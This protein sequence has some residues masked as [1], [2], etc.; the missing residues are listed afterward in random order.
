LHAYRTSDF[1]ERFM[2]EPS[3]ADN[4][5]VTLIVSVRVRSGEEAAFAEW[6]LRWQK[7]VLAADGALSCDLWPAAPP[8]QDDSVAVIRFASQ[9]ALRAWRASD[10]HNALIAEVS[11]LV[12]GGV[13][14]QLVGAV[15]AA[16]YVERAATELIVTR[17]LPGKEAAY[18][19]WYARIAK[20]QAAAPGFAGA[21]VHPPQAEEDA[22]TTVLRFDTPEHLNG[23]LTSPVRLA[24]LEE[25]EHLSD[26]L[27]FQ[28][29]DT[30]F[31]G[32]TAFDPKTGKPPSRW[33]TAC[34]VVLVLLPVVLLE[35][36]YLDPLI[37]H[38]HRT[39]WTLV[40]ICGG[41][42]LTTYPLMPLATR[43]FRGWLFPEEGPWWSSYAYAA[44]ILA[45]LA[46]EIAAFWKLF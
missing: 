37:I 32:W 23:W 40:N 7:A 15:A 8:D 17:V 9:D 41:V 29:F 27:V 20:A 22:W 5:R 1:K 42:T 6:Q 30:S 44:A 46:I 10:V 36:K 45:I 3:A 28:P 33:R 19:Q 38:W 34:L 14:T 31:P 18:R 21:F 26:R 4:L 2:S 16:Y 24:L 13:V 11:P 25:S 12:E 35:V 43:V 39:L